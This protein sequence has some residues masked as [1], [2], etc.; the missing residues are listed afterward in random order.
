MDR[1]AILCFVLLL[2]CGCSQ[3]DLEKARQA[4]IDVDSYVA[5][6][7]PETD[8][9]GQDSETEGV[10]EAEDD[11][12]LLGGAA[13]EGLVEEKIP[14]DGESLEAD[15]A[16]S[17]LEE[18]IPE[19]TDVPTGLDAIKQAEE[20]AEGGEQVDTPLLDAAL[21]GDG[22]TEPGDDTAAADQPDQAGA[23][24]TGDEQGQ[25]QEQAAEQP[26][27]QAAP[28]SGGG[29]LVVIDAGHQRKANLD[30]EPIGPNAS[31]TK[32]K[33]SGGTS[34]RTSGL[35][36]YELTLI[37]AQK[38]QSILQ[39]RGYS[40]IM[41]RNSH[42]VN[43]SNSERAAVANNAGADVFIRIHANGSDNTSTNGAL[44]MCQSSSNPYNGNLA[45]KSYALSEKVLN[46]LV[47]K[48]G[49]KSLGV[50]R[51]DTMSGI[52]WC[53]VPVTIVEMGFM[54]NPQEDMLM[55]TDDYQNKLAA[56]MADGID[57]Y[58]AQ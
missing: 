28:S 30:K 35:A 42:D 40:V 5:G 29:R 46:G 54:T 13:G 55:A 31:E 11:Q 8:G 48:C 53:K 6:Q 57:A 50:S 20:S 24:E 19:T 16:L 26:Q 3:E 41:V 45:S 56:G 27:P 47:A 10:D 2:V 18:N 49:C 22:E 39:Q 51:T 34:G 1:I 14:E 44:T 36:E 38:L 7:S 25:P 21:E 4:G 58:F 9:S 15:E 32:I 12:A 43:I 33:V 23:G 37:V 17:I 52:N